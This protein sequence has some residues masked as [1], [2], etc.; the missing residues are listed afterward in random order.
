MLS[1]HLPSR[2][3]LHHAYVVPN[4][5]VLGDVVAHLEN[6]IGAPLAGNP[7]VWI[8]E[9]EQFTIDDARLLKEKSI[10]KPVSID[11]TVLIVATAVITTDAQQAL[12]KVLEEPS[13]HTHIFLLIPP[14]TQLLPTVISRV[15]VV[16]H[17]SDQSSETSE[18]NIR[19]QVT[20]FIANQP[21][22]RLLRVQK[23]VDGKDVAAQRHFVALLVAELRRHKR[24][25]AITSVYTATQFLGD[26]GSSP[27]LIFEHLATTLPVVQSN[28]V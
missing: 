21:A 10:R 4:T 23:L 17:G 2:D 1:T 16:P 22:E 20:T 12:L 24:F 3:S 28:H 9:T 25:D 19:A 5:I 18:K 7:D 6:L 14:T 13:P 15:Y 26:R 8:Y 27:K 11:R